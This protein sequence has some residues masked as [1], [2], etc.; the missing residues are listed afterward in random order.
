MVFL[1]KDMM[2][3][4]VQQHNICTT[5]PLF[6]RAKTFHALD[7]AAT[8]LIGR[9]TSRTLE[10]GVAGQPC[11]EPRTSCSR[12]EQTLFLYRFKVLWPINQ[13]EM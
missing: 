8:I 7:R 3:D 11:R 13:D 1:D 2:M 12:K 5:M 4:N 10:T 6:E 9:H